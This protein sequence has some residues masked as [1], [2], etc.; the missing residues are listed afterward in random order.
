[1]W[2]YHPN[3]QVKRALQRKS[4][5]KKMEEIRKTVFMV[6]TA[7]LCVRWI[8][9]TPFDWVKI[10]KQDTRTMHYIVKP[11]SNQLL[12]KL[13]DW[14]RIQNLIIIDVSQCPHRSRR[15][16]SLPW[17]VDRAIIICIYFSIGTRCQETTPYKYLSVAKFHVIKYAFPGKLLNIFP[18]NFQTP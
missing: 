12:F 17:N 7:R 2:M 3:W 18:W 8:V 1:M 11:G 16:I 13:T 5:L 6:S 15:I 4:C 9:E 10:T 14:K